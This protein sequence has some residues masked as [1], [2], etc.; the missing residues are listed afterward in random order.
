MLMSSADISSQHDGVKMPI[1][2]AASLHTKWTKLVPEGVS[3]GSVVVANGGKGYWD[4]WKRSCGE[5]CR[6][7]FIP[8]HFYGLTSAEFI[9]YVKVNEDYPLS[10]LLY[11]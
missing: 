3:I 9:D 1:E 10:H 11:V 4:E 5:S 8:L 6:Y 7:D 2:E